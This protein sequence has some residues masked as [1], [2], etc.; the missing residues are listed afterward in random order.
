MLSL[1]EATHF[2]VHG[3]NILEDAL[4]FTTT[5]LS[6]YLN[7]NIDNPLIGLVGRSLKY[8]LRKSL[9]RL[10]ARHYISVYHKLDWHNQVLLDLA[11]CNFNLVQKLHQ[12]ELGEITR[13]TL[14]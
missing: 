8:P 2:R 7:S 3:E 13:Y 4:E 9:N 11:K 5:H 10:V 1:F 6:L 12:V 14:I